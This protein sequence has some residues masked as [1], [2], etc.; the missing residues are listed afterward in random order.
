MKYEAETIKRYYF[1]PSVFGFRLGFIF[2]YRKQNRF[3]TMAEMDTDYFN[4]RYNFFGRLELY[5]GNGNFIHVFKQRKPEKTNYKHVLLVF[6]L[7]N[8]FIFLC[9]QSIWLNYFGCGTGISVT[10]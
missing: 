5:S 4:K 3:E 2:M 1:E 8:C 10:E 9:K 6:D 7:R